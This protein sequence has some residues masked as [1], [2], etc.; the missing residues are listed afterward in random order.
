MRI[1]DWSSDVCSSDLESAG[2]LGEVGGRGLVERLVEGCGGHVAHQSGD[3][4]PLM[5]PS[6]NTT[7]PLPAR[8]PT[9][10]RWL[11]PAVRADSLARTSVGMGQREHVRVDLGERRT[12]KN[13]KIKRYR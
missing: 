2:E 7:A 13:K 8:L 11:E 3:V 9:I 6:R 4:D 10:S 5:A 1:S 12:T